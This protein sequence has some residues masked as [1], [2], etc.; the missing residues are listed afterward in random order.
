[1][2]GQ[3]ILQDPKEL[4]DLITM[5]NVIQKFLAKQADIDKILKVMQ[6]KVIKCTLT[7]WDKGNSSQILNYFSF[8]EHLSV[9]VTE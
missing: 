9:Y 6:R 4:N 2:T 7:S 5:G 8:Q 1:M 3:I